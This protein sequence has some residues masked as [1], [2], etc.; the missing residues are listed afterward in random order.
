MD[1]THDNTRVVELLLEHNAPHDSDKAD[2]T[3]LIHAAREGH[4]DVVKLLLQYGATVLL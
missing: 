3:P 2:W 4:F 1:R